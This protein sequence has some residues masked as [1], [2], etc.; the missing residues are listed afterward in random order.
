MLSVESLQKILISVA[1]GA[2]CVAQNGVGDGGSLGFDVD[3][4]VGDFAEALGATVGAA[5]DVDGL[6][7]S[8]E[9]AG[10]FFGG[11]FYVGSAGIG[12]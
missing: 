8:A 1:G 10:F 7:G 5:E 3:A 9:A 12:E 2:V 11:D 4:A 6:D